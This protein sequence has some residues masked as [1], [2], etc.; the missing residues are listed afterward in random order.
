MIVSK[1]QTVSVCRPSSLDYQ[2][3]YFAVIIDVISHNHRV[4]EEGEKIPNVNKASQL[5]LTPEGRDDLIR[6]LLKMTDVEPED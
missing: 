1:T 6:K 3:R 2:K 5:C 4:N